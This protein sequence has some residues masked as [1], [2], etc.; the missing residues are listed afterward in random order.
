MTRRAV[1]LAA[2]R[3]TRM[4][5]L[6][7]NIPKPMIEVAGKSML[8][9]LLEGLADAGIQQAAVITGYRAEQLEEHARA[10]RGPALEFIRQKE[11]LGT[12]HAIQLARDFVDQ[13]PFF[14]GW[15][16]IVVAA[17]NYGRVIER[18]DHDAV[19]A[20]NAVE[21]PTEGAA[22]YT[23]ASGRVTRIIEKPA[24]G[25]STTPWNNAGFGILGPSIWSH[26][27]AVAPS[28]RGELELAD[29]LTSMLDAGA[30]IVTTPVDGPWFDVG[31]PKRLAE[32]ERALGGMDEMNFN[33]S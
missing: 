19:L 29:A 21:D 24:P 26:I 2:G 16:D 11:P 13:E 3:G 12:A 25:T 17:H 7:D 33:P 27:E 30:D 5:R 14:F 10:V 8:A 15:S 22:V 18:A 9:R 32:V 6:T 28:A 4:G 31:T 23:D 1:V 20:V